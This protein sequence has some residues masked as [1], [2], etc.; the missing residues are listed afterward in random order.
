M[1]AFGFDLVD[2]PFEREFRL[3]VGGEFGFL[4]RLFNQRVE[5]FEFGFETEFFVV[6]PAFQLFIFFFVK[7]GIALIAFDQLCGRP[8]NA[9]K[10]IKELRGRGPKKPFANRAEPGLRR[11]PRFLRAFKTRQERFKVNALK[12]A[13]AIHNQRLRKT[14]MTPH[15][16]TQR[17]HA[18]AVT[19]RIKCQ[20]DRQQTTRISVAEECHPMIHRLISHRVINLRPVTGGNSA[21]AG[22]RLLFFQPTAI[23]FLSLAFLPIFSGYSQSPEPNED[24]LLAVV[25]RERLPDGSLN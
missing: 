14:V 7:P 2:A 11:W 16:L 20:P 5:V 9:E 12:V 1:G 17:H 23:A 4:A 3:Q 18:G 19:W 24:S 13:P 10:V 22:R 6:G 15:A 21:L 25:K 8:H